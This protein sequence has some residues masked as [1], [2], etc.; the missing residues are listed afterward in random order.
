MPL[1]LVRVA[2]SLSGKSG[3]DSCH[4]LLPPPPPPPPSS[5]GV[6]T[7]LTCSMI[8][9]HSFLLSDFFECQNFHNLLDLALHL[10][11]NLF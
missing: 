3:F 2:L 1:V 6:T 5:V 4:T 10:L 7:Q 9:F 8:R 11:P